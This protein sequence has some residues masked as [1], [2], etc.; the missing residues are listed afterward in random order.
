MIPPAAHE[1]GYHERAPGSICE[2]PRSACTGSTIRTQYKRF[3]QRDRPEGES[4]SCRLRGECPV[5]LRRKGEGLQPLCRFLRGLKSQ[6]LSAAARS[7]T[8]A[9][10]PCRKADLS[11]QNCGPIAG[12]ATLRAGITSSRLRRAFFVRRFCWVRRLELGRVAAHPSTR[13][14]PPWGRRSRCRTSVCPDG[15]RG[16]R[17]RDPGRA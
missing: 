16:R 7:C 1:A 6:P 14:H 17:A 8:L 2:S 5:R 12:Q 11:A 13:Q 9:R 3:A 4:A 10:N 15:E